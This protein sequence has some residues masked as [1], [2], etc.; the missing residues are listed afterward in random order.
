MELAQDSVADDARLLLH[1]QLGVMTHS[2]RPTENIRPALTQ[3]P[4]TMPAHQSGY[5]ARAPLQERSSGKPVSS[6]G[7]RGDLF[8]AHEWM[9]GGLADDKSCCDASASNVGQMAERLQLESV[10]YIVRQKPQQLSS[11]L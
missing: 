1:R 3:P 2:R 10:G 8:P 4:I 5:C 6:S 7:E 11:R 9:H